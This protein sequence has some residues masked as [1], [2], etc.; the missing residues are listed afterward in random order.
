MVTRAVDELFGQKDLSAVDRYWAEPY[1][2]HDP[3]LASGVEP[4]R[5]FV[6]Q[7][8]PTPGFKF[9]RTR[10]LGDGDLVAV[11]SRYTGVG[12]G[13]MVVFDIFRVQ[14]G[15]LVE[16]WDGKQSEA[17]PS[18][19][20][21]TMLEGPTEIHDED[22]T[23]ANR[24]V[25]IDF[26]NAGPVRGETVEIDTL[27]KFFDG[28]AYIQHN[29]RIADGLSGLGAFIS[30]LLAQGVS[31]KYTQVHRVLA[32]G[33]FVLAQSEGQIAGTTNAFYDLFRVQNGKLAEHWDTIEE[34]PA[35]TKS[36]LPVF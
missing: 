13:P 28:D 8:V 9:D 24:Q 7:V 20:G 15:K 14:N 31:F 18:P 22:R 5:E 11:H 17:N 29:P 21:H 3:S 32:E 4:F 33:N 34:V 30:G 2:Q 1:L 23:E 26:L 16:H 10:V 19:S 25:V 12:P 6:R 27:A 35:T 36:G